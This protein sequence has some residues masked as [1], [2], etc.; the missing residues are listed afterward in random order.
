MLLCFPITYLVDHF[1]EI[2]AQE[3]RELI[4]SANHML[5]L[6]PNGACTLVRADVLKDVGGYRED[7]GAQDGFDLWTK[8]IDKYKSANTNLPLFYYRRH[9]TNLTASTQ[10]IL[11]ARQRIK[12]DAAEEKL[13]ALH[14]IIGVIPCR[15]NFDFATDLWKEEIAGKSLLDR[16][17]EV[18]LSSDLFD[19][20]VVT[21]DNPQAEEIVKKYS[22]KRLRFMLRDSSATIRSASIVPTLEMICRELDPNMTGITIQRFIQSPFV[23]IETLKEA[24]STLAMNDADSSHGVEEIDQTVF[25]R[26]RNGLEPLN[27]IGSFRSDF[28]LLYRDVRSCVATRNQVL[29]T[30]SL[31]GK[32]AVSF[33]VSAAECFFID[34]G[35]KLRLARLM[36]NERLMQLGKVGIIVAARTGSTRLPGKALLPLNGMPMILFLL[37]RLKSLQGAGVVLA[38]TELESGDDHLA[39]SWRGPP[40]FR[41]FAAAPM[42]WW[43][44]MPRRLRSSAST[45]WG[46]CRAIAPLWMPRWWIIACSRRPALAASIS[47]TPKAR[48]RWGWTLNSIPQPQWRG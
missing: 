37:E 41:C 23:G 13:D 33:V 10:R 12:Q 25:R 36:A 30:G 44:A 34:S 4:Y 15:R 20:V 7:L 14:P 6:P 48:S 3:R 16:D 22:D 27:R 39:E 2:F 40:A 11:S 8:V 43:R 47:P 19:H 17:I 21:C 31:S 28:D 1:G 38:T 26:T 29:T 24:A 9:G 5:D 18:C 35:H 46:G 42:T 45:R 32:S